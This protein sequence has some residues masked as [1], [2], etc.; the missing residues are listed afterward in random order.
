MSRRIAILTHSINPR[1]GVVHAMQ[2]AEALQARGEDVT[3]LAPALPGRDF[4]RRPTC[5]R[6]LIPA[7]PVQGTVPMVRTRIREIAA[8]LSGPGAPRFDL[9]HAQDPISGNA[10]ADLVEDGRIPGFV[11]TVHHLDA[12]AEP[13]L[14]AW[15]D[16]AVQAADTLFCVSRVWQRTLAARYD[17]HAAIVGNGVDRRRYA[18]DAAPRDAALRA[19][20]AAGP[21]PLFL[22]LGGI[23]DRKNILTVLDAFLAVRRLRPEAR[24][25]VAGGATLLDHA[26][27]GRAFAARLADSGAA[28][29]VRLAGVIA[30]C[31]MPSL[32]RMSDA[33]LSVS[34]AEGFG[35]CAIE[36]LACGVP[37]IVSKVAPF[38]EHLRSTEVLWADPD[39]AASIA[40][41]M[42]AALDPEVAALLRPAGLR[43]ALRFDWQSVAAAHADLYDM[44]VAAGAVA[45]GVP[46]HA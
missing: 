13:E 29:S 19:G 37:A 20:L 35:L 16:R 46:A 14:A 10:L 12:F 18:P 11:R 28:G 36:A 23:E 6:L 5:R 43:A 44:P 32:Y 25:L 8:F 45:N 33:L 4:A 17:R 40:R 31:D 41:Q 15:Q 26:G 22:A 30:D 1:G 34:R 7:T 38:T 27:T 24:L 2:L 9:L 39:D 21:G 3:L 42:L